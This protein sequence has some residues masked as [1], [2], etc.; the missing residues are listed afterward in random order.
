MLASTTPF[1]FKSSRM[2]TYFSFF[3]NFLKE[4]GKWIL[5]AKNRQVR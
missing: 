2:D 3:F 5:P 4:N 1:A